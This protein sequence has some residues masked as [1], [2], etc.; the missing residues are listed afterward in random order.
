MPVLFTV[1]HLVEGFFHL[2]SKVAVNDF[3]EMLF[4]HLND[5]KGDLR[6][7]DTLLFDLNVLTCLQNGDGRGIG[8]WTSYT[9]TLQLFNEARFV[10]AC[11]RFGEVLLFFDL[12]E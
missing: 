11:R 10:V 9:E 3:R 12:I 4:K 5:R 1:C 8:T 2:C 7:V 6:R